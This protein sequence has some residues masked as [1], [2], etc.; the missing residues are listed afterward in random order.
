MAKLQIVW[1][2]PSPVKHTNRW[3]ANPRSSTLGLGSYVIEELVSDGT[4]VYWTVKTRLEIV[5]CKGQAA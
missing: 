3:Y 5:S 1:R 4:L 2:N